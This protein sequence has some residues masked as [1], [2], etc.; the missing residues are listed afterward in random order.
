MPGDNRAYTIR[1]HTVVNGRDLYNCSFISAQATLNAMEVPYMKV[2]N[3]LCAL[4]ADTLY[5]YRN[6]NKWFIAKHRHGHVFAVLV[7]DT[8][9]QGWFETFFVLP[10]YYVSRPGNWTLEVA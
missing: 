10:G 1:S 2:T 8:S 7:V 9:K 3:L 6:E 4:A 5:E